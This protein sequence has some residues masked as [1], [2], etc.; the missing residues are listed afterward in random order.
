M[1]EPSSLQ[2]ALDVVSLV[3]LHGELTVREIG[4]ALGLPKSTA[5]R[6]VNSLL[7][8]RLLEAQRVPDGDVYAVG[9][10]IEE[11]NAGQLSWRSLLQTARGP[12]EAL[13]D[14]SGETVGLHM[15]YSERRVLLTQAV[16]E[17]PHRWVYN[18]VMVPMPLHG[19]AAAR[20]LLAMLPD[21]DME[22]LAA[23]DQRPGAG[24]PREA[25]A[26]FIE[27]LRE[28]RARDLS[29]T[30]DE[31]NPGVSSI[32]VPVIRDTR[33]G[34]PLAVLSLAAPSIRMTPEAIERLLPMLRRTSQVIAQA[35]TA[36]G[37]GAALPST[38]ASDASVRRV[39][40]T[41]EAAHD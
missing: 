38:L 14:Q 29:V 5:H 40:A 26:R 31:I 9:K 41:S 25:L 32:V 39:A 36:A 33:H 3:A 1:S 34:H 24:N 17:R 13:R 35:C 18:N 10:L 2:K 21:A 23:R 8:V 12:L 11:L 6:L 7:K 27:S 37:R 16:S 15:L 30:S 19:G 22:R 4:E 28:V 20:M